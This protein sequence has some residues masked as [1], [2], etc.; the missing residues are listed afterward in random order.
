MKATFGQL[1]QW[2]VSRRFY[3]AA[4]EHFPAIKGHEVYQNGLWYLFFGTSFDQ[5]TDRLLL[6]R[7]TLAAIAKQDPANFVSKHFLREVEQ[8]VLGEGNLR[9]SEWRQNHCRQLLKLKLGEFAETL[10]GEYEGRWDN[11]GFVFL[12]GEPWS[13]AKAKH[14]RK[15]ERALAERIVPDCPHAEFIQRYLN[16]LAR[17]QFT[18]IIKSN[19][20]NAF[21]FA[22]E[23][24]RDEKLQRELRLLRRVW[25][26]PQ[27]FY[28]A[29]SNGNTARLFTNGHIPDL[30]REVRKILTKDWFEADLRSSQL[31]IC[32]WLWRIEPLMRC[33]SDN[34]NIWD[35]L[36][37]F[38]DFP[39]RARPKAKK[40]FKKAL[41]SIC[42]GMG[43]FR[44]S[45]CIGEASDW[46]ELGRIIASRFPE[47]PLI[48]E[49][50]HARSIELEK[51]AHS[52]GAQ[53]CY[54][55]WIKVGNEIQP[56]D[57][58][59][60]I[61]QSWEMKLIFPAFQLAAQTEDFKIMIFQHD[62]FSVHFTR[63]PEQW[64]ERIQS[65]VN[66]R[67]K[68]LEIPT[69]LEWDESHLENTNKELN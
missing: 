3:E 1:S 30:K 69:S 14:A 22:V 55:K 37:S 7:D 63:R 35:Y 41:Y 31:C 27:P 8:K 13:A 23:T 42:Y 26:Q 5:D 59:A 66:E 64:R 12:N 32:A 49:L 58:L 40:I 38:F 24:L 43:E 29:S 18:K 33:L 53:T 9:W 21:S 28:S 46:T 16:E 60:Q 20:R 48:R 34:K 25:L 57:I 67:A 6:C 10:R 19:Y 36:F 4:F 2:V 44:L 50:L 61:A 11:S 15:A 45:W 39:E 62:G 51:I 65:V 56:R 54:G 47:I 68:A 17:N 52:G